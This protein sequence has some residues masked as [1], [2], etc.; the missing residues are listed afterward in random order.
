VL[1]NLFQE[2]LSLKNDLQLGSGPAGAVDNNDQVK[3]LGGVCLNGGKSGEMAFQKRTGS[4]I[5]PS[6]GRGRNAVP[7][8]VGR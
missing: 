1:H 6:G 3:T 2:F 5:V 7:L 8:A 4:K